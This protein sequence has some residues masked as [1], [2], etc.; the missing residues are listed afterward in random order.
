MLVSCIVK[1]S[2]FVIGISC[3]LHCKLVL[4][5]LICAKKGWRQGEGE[6]DEKRETDRQRQSVSLFVC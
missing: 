3:L 4:S 6:K 1:I 2:Y 5:A